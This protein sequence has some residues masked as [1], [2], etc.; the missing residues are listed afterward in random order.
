MTHN[1]ELIICL[2]IFVWK[3]RLFLGTGCMCR[4]EKKQSTLR[5][6]WGSSARRMSEGLEGGRGDWEK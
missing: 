4:R 1:C 3:I 2:D 5:K 6:D